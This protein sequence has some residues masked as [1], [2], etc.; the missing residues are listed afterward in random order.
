MIGKMPANDAAYSMRDP[1]LS[2]VAQTTTVWFHCC[3]RLAYASRRSA[4]Y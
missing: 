1:K 4:G 3:V 2:L